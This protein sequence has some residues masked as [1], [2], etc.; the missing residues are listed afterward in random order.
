MPATAADVLASRAAWAVECADVLAFLAGLPDGCVNCC[1]TSP[2]YY[3]L[4]DY[5]VAGQIGLEDTPAAYVER[6]AG[7]FRE[8]RRVL[9][10]SGTLWLNIG[11]SF[12]AN[13]RYD[14]AY[15]AKRERPA[16]NG[17]AR[18]LAKVGAEPRTGIRG[19][20]IKPKDLIGVPW[21]LAFALRADGWYLRQECPW[22][23]RNPMP[24]SVTDRPS[25]ACEKVFL[26]SKSADYFFDM[27]AVR[28]VGSPA[29][30]KDKR[31]G[32]DRVF[33]L[34]NGA[35]YGDSRNF[36]SADLW[37]DSVG[38]L[39]AD[40]G[41]MLGF[42]VNPAPYKG[43]HFAV[44]PPKLVEPCVL[45]GTS[46]GGCCAECGSPRRRVTERATVFRKRPNAH[47]KYK[48]N[49]AKTNG[50]P[51]QTKAGVDVRTL[52]WPTCDCGTDATV[53]AVVLDPFAGSGTVIAVALNL[54]RRGIGCDLNAKYVDLCR[55]RM[56]SVTP[57]LC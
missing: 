35:G 13:G 31:V 8:V 45:A 17:G 51:D 56:S 16:L 10:K 23:K 34:E 22:V 26:F 53:P 32:T 11:D 46:D 54:N 18:E 2:P 3:A 6:L 47:V 30:A 15:E 33:A 48:D 1:V 12:A 4:R 55:R 36:R 7:V 38:M 37:F 28:R 40:D 20:G 5:G 29:T 57:A 9:H 41:Q 19:D 21:L 50:Q 24:E 42:D 43:A 14:A 52:G 25:T 44:M 27:E 39:L 49:R